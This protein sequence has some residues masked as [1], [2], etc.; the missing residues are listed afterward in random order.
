M[1]L[2]QKIVIVLLSLSTIFFAI[3][4]LFTN[5]EMTKELNEQLFDYALL[6]QSYENVTE[7][8]E[9]AIEIIEMLR[10]YANEEEQKIIEKYYQNKSR[11]VEEFVDEFEEDMNQMLDE[12][13]K[14]KDKA[15]NIVEEQKQTNES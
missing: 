14:L 13:D 1:T 15:E 10:H 2:K 7:D 6:E 12:A 9:K 4:A 8:C 5:S 3:L 11:S